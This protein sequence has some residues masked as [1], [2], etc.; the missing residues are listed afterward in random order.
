MLLIDIYTAVQTGG[1]ILVML[2]LEYPWLVW[3][4]CDATK[5]EVSRF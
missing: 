1:F 3:R 5:T 2:A 4:E